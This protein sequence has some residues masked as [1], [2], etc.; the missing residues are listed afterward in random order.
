MKIQGGA[1]MI[2]ICDNPIFDGLFILF[3]LASPYI[4]VR[5]I[6]WCFAGAYKDIKRRRRIKEIER[7]IEELDKSIH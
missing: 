4:V 5:Y 7:D 2:Y 1:D 3:L 6:I